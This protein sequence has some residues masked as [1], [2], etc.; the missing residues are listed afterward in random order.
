MR[1]STPDGTVAILSS[2][3]TS[4][5]PAITAVFF[6]SRTG[7]TNYFMLTAIF[8]WPCAISTMIPK[9]VSIILLRIHL[10]Q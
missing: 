1:K 3:L 4:T 10:S 8:W 5:F 6:V 2:D 9:S 7:P